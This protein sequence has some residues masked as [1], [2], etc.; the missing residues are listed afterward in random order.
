MNKWFRRAVGTVGIAGG[1]LLLGA[2]TA[3][4]DDSVS[5]AKDPQLLHGLVEDLFKPAGG[6]NN[7]GLSLDTPGRRV[8]AGLVPDGPLTASAHRGDAGVV[9]HTP[10]KD[11]QPKDVLVTAP[12]SKVLGAL[13]IS[14]ATQ[15]AGLGDLGGV[16]GING[17]DG[18]HGVRGPDG[19]NGLNG[20]NGLGAPTGLTE[21][22]TPELPLLDALGILSNVSSTDDAGLSTVGD[23]LPRV[24]DDVA[25]VIPTAAP[26]SALVSD[27][28]ID[29]ATDMV[30]VLPATPADEADLPILG[31]LLGG[32]LGSGVPVL[33]DVRTGGLPIG[34]L[35][36]GGG[37]PALSDVPN[38]GVPVVGSLLDS[39]SGLPANGNLV[40]VPGGTAVPLGGR[41]AERP[42]A[43]DQPTESALLAGLPIF[44]ALAGGLPVPDELPLSRGELP[45]GLP[46]GLPAGLPANLPLNAPAT[47][48]VDLP[49]LTHLPAG[50]RSVANPLDAPGGDE[51]AQQSGVTGLPVPFLGNPS[52]DPAT[53]T[54]LPIFGDALRALR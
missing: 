29:R 34:G 1:F 49:S 53:L 54:E 27:G 30:Q 21:S 48:P 38:G 37:L 7:L 28:G 31:S 40:P 43:A 15:T 17:L 39:G 11:G 20:L 19:L 33:S 6:P 10:G 9:V 5:A 16:N 25:D 50:E 14:N 18:V 24:R 36:T 46:G 12:V 8:S 13:P 41:A 51:W 45:A 42:V 32:P 23:A 4:A 2:G 26:G 47:V 44:D 3:H 52:V 22:D 35:P